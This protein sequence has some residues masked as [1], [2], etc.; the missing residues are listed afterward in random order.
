MRRP[1]VGACSRFSSTA[2]LDQLLAR[3]P[4]RCDVAA[5]QKLLAE[6]LVAAGAPY[7][8]EHLRAAWEKPTP[9]HRDDG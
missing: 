8:P 5:Y 1:G 3:M 4:T 2:R 6:H 9:R 7:R